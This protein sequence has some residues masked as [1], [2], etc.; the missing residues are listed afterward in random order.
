MNGIDLF[1]KGKASISWGKSWLDSF[2]V[3]GMR[4]VDRKET[5]LIK[6]IMKSPMSLAEIM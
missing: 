6:I 5:S 4:V 3:G 2:K 1:I